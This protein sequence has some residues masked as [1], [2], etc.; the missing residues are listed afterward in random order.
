MSNHDVIFLKLINYCMLTIIKKLKKKKETPWKI[1]TAKKEKQKLKFKKGRK[2]YLRGKE[3]KI[4]QN[5]MPM[6]T[7]NNFSTYVY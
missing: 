7:E 6:K 2:Q 4:R 3:M 5:V 1:T